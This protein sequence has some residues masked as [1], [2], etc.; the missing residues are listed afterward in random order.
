MVY[1]FRT[2]RLSPTAPGWLATADSADLR[3]RLLSNLFANLCVLAQGF[4]GIWHYPALV[5][6]EGVSTRPDEGFRLRLSYMQVDDFVVTLGNHDPAP[7]FHQPAH[8]WAAASAAEDLKMTNHCWASTPTASAQRDR[9]LCGRHCRACVGCWGMYDRGDQSL[10]SA[11]WPGSKAYYAAVTGV[12]LPAFPA[13]VLGGLLV[14]GAP[15]PFTE[16]VIQQ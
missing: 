1:S 16:P 13:L 15:K 11:L 8:A 6:P 7:L 14:C 9:S 2:R 3:D 4:A 5:G 12:A 10:T